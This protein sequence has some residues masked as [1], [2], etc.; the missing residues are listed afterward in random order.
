MTTR[1][2]RNVHWDGPDHFH[3]Q[4]S[5]DGRTWVNFSARVDLSWIDLAITRSVEAYERIWAR[6]DAYG[7][8]GYTPPQGYDWSGIRDSSDEAVEA[9]VAIAQEYVSRAEFLAAHGLT[10]QEAPAT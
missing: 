4:T 2:Y 7:E 9:M 3:G 6:Q 5:Y 8:P 10:E 1:L